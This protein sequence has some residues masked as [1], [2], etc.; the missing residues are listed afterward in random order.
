MSRI[1]IRSVLRAIRFGEEFLFLPLPTSNER[2]ADLFI[3]S[4]CSMDVANLSRR[5]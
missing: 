1:G 2:S 4:F 3:V 5:C